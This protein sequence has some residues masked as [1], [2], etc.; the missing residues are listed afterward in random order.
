VLAISGV[1]F[2]GAF[3]AHSFISPSLIALALSY[4]LY[5]SDDLMFLVII[6]AWFEQGMVSPERILQYIDLPAEG[7]S[8]QLE[9]FREDDN[10]ND[11][12]H[13]RSGGITLP[14][15][16]WPSQGI[17]EFRGVWFRYQPI[18][19]TFDKYQ[20]R[21]SQGDDIGAGCVLKNL[22]FKTAHKEKIGI[23]GR[24]GAGKSSL[25]MCLFRISEIARGAVYIDGVDV[26]TLSLACLRS[27]IEI[28]PQNPVVFKGSLRNY[29]DPFEEYSDD[30]IWASLKKARLVSMVE[31][32]GSANGNGL[33]VDIAENG[34]NM[35]VGQRQMLVMSR[36]LLREAKI[37]V[38]VSGISVT[39][40]LQHNVKTSILRI[41][42]HFILCLI[43]IAG[44]SHCCNGY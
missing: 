2:V 35:S 1:L 28:V 16:T 44:R 31:K 33:M 13:N 22:N 10:S 43:H 12:H 6:W 5:I 25:T 24:T 3:S 34:E 18:E 7:T 36:A 11:D 42:K 17:I 39:M 23:V 4:S 40:Q 20:A 21:N 19:N 8:N 30:Q 27:A 37:L 41:C 32:M 15:G 29:I 14:T 9:L 38:M 26:S